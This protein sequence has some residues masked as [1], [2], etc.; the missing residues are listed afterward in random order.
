MFVFNFLYWDYR[1]V[2]FS[3][4]KNVSWDFKM[5]DLALSKISICFIKRVDNLTCQ[6]FA[7][8]NKNIIKKVFSI[9]DSANHVQYFVIIKN[10]SKRLNSIFK[11]INV[12]L[13]LKLHKLYIFYACKSDKFKIFSCLIGN[14]RASTTQD[15]KKM[16][17]N[18]V[19]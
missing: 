12:K 6:R 19:C 3:W 9:V 11:K 1:V 14:S 16:V 15:I 5:V 8:K 4:K 18:P 7:F 13:T 2:I 17:S 10:R